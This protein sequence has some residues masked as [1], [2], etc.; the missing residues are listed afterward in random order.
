MPVLRPDVFMVLISSDVDDDTE[1]DEDD[2]LLI[3]SQVSFISL[4]WTI[5]YVVMLTGTVIAPESQTLQETQ[6]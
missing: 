5:V 4:C 1:D 2:D 3:Q 6:T